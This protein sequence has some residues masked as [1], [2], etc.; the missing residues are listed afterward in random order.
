MTQ[1]D[2]IMQHVPVEQLA[3]RFGVDESQV[4]QATQQA[5]PAL[6]GGLK[7]NADDPAGASSIMS[8]LTQ[9]AGGV[10]SSVDQIDT[11]DGQQI[12]GHI[13]GGNT[14]EVVNRLG[15]TQGG[16]TGDLVQKLLPVLAPIV[17]SW[18]AG[19]LGGGGGLGGALG[20]TLGGQ[21]QGTG[22]A[23]PAPGQGS[24][25]LQDVLGS[26]LG[27]HGDSGSGGGLLGGV[28]GGLLGQGRR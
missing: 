17:M 15:N 11:Q 7:A 12:V 2:E 26:I 13:F 23:A 4:R 9:H 3:Q 8:A 19:R 18:L 16:G 6:L 25:G 10:P 14:D 22:Q 28:L 24:G 1:Y 20:G 27:G 21:Q 5:L